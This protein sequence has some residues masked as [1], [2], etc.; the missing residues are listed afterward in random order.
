MSRQVGWY[1]VEEFQ[2]LA[3]KMVTGVPIGERSSVYSGPNKDEVHC[4]DE[5]GERL[6]LWC[7]SKVQRKDNRRKP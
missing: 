5:V 2:E 6:A 7:S 4:S 3:H 1:R